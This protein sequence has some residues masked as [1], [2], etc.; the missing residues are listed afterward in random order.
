MP[1]L[2]SQ[3][4]EQLRRRFATGKDLPTLK[5]FIR[6]RKM[7]REK[8]PDVRLDLPYEIVASGAAEARALSESGTTE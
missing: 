4:V 6:Y 3:P 5:Q 1:D 7:S 2:E 8:C